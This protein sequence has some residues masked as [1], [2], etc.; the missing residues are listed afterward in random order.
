ME[1]EYSES[2]SSSYAAK[3][4]IE[5]SISLKSDAKEALLSAIKLAETDE[6]NEECLEILSNF[7]DADFLMDV[8]L[9]YCDSENSENLFAAILLAVTST[10]TRFSKKQ[11]IRLMESLRNVSNN[12]P[13]GI[14]DLYKENLLKNSL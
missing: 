7:E 11:V 14:L 5:K 4:M 2:E 1:V 3:K 12:M 9:R 10:N 8:I 13:E 6:E